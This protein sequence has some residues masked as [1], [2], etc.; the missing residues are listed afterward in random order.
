V[1]DPV[2]AK[3]PRSGRLVP[4]LSG[5]AMCSGLVAVGLTPAPAAAA[6][7]SNALVC[8]PTLSVASLPSL[9]A[10]PS[11]L[12]D[13][14]AASDSNVWAVGA[15]VPTGQHN[16]RTLI[17]HWNGTAWSI[18]AGANEGGPTTRNELLSIAVVS[19]T[20]VWAVGD[21]GSANPEPV[22]PL[23][24]HFVGGTW[25]AVPNPDL[26]AGLHYLT[27]VAA[28]S[29]TDVWAVGYSIIDAGEIFAPLVEHWNGSTWSAV[30]VPTPN[31][32]P[33]GPGSDLQAVWGSGPSDVWII[34]ATG[35]GSGGLVEHWNGKAWTIVAMPVVSPTSVGGGLDAISGKASDDV[36]AVGSWMP[37][38]YNFVSLV[39]H[40]N[41]SAWSVIP[42][43]DVPTSS[44]DYL[45]A[46]SEVTP[47][48]VWAVGNDDISGFSGTLVEHW[49]GTAWSVVPS[50]NPGPDLG[51]G[52]G[53]P[54]NQLNGVAASSDALWTA[55][56]FGAPPIPAREEPLIEQQC[57]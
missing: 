9:T 45:R 21:H 34:G 27:G 32:G 35:S 43:A 6:V 13:V 5:L 40:W 17:E 20:N 56:V 31:P 15:L 54:F 39:E 48:D 23:I 26:G 49:N 12:N 29:A 25:H 22:R 30:A 50:P 42:S 14:A 36:W 52:G 11:W 57:G 16:Q 19:A 41:G 38:I 51:E 18:Q 53:Y 46:V 3:P 44:A 10:S 4:L 47:T 1:T 7:A 24:E 28:I 33:F 37:N 8:G 2:G 55:G